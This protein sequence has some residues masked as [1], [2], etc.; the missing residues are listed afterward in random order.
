MMNE[1]INKDD[2]QQLDDNQLLKEF[3]NSLSLTVFHLQKMAVIWDILTNRGIDLSEYKKGLIEFVPL[4]AQ[5]KLIPEFV[6]DFAGQRNLINHVSRIPVE[7]Q[8]R[9]L[10]VGKVEKLTILEDGAEV[11]Q[12][13]DLNEIK[14][15]ELYQIFGS[16]K[17]RTIED[18]R[19]LLIKQMPKSK[20]KKQPKLKTYRKVSIDNNQEYLVLGSEA[21][22]KLSEVLELIKAT[23]N[24]DI[25]KEVK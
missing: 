22:V 17:L 14:S 13:L 15:G 5:N 3:K 8:R 19:L 12:N 25:P 11:V 20:P 6:T 2:L 18:Q 4:I 21:K 24:V 16:D 7:E 1:L 10:K 9:L 23:Y